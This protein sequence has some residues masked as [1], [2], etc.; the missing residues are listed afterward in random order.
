MT[1]YQQTYGGALYD[2]ALESNREEKISEDLSLIKKMLK[3]E[4]GYRKLLSSPAVG[5]DEKKELLSK[6][7]SESVDEYTLNF[8]Y[9]LCDNNHLD[10]LSGCI[11]E[12][13]RRYKNDR[14]IFDV[15]VTS[16]VEL[17]ESQKERLAAAVEKKTGKKACLV[18]KIDPSVMGGIRLSAGG[19]E[20]DGTIAMHLHKLEEMLAR[21]I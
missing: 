15:I 19:R 11:D 20:Y 6:A 17:T 4:D 8:L 2:L 13:I 5:K 1:K 14:N 10:E 9:L 16:A 18:E 12:Y 3:E 21:S 7:W